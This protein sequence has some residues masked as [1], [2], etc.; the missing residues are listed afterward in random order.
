MTNGETIQHAYEREQL[1]IQKLSQSVLRADCC[2]FAYSLLQIDERRPFRFLASTLS[3]ILLPVV[4]PNMD[5]SRQ[6]LKIS[7]V[8]ELQNNLTINTD[9]VISITVG[10]RW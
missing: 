4:V 10:V 8:L 7:T 5:L 9:K 2:N 6:N 1:I 3:L